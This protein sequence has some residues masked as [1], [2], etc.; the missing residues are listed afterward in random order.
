MTFSGDLRGISLADVFQNVA[1]NRS[2][3]W[4]EITAKSRTSHVRFFEGAVTGFSLGAGERLV[5]PEFLVQRG[6]VER[7]TMRRLLTKHRRSKKSPG[8]LAA[9]AKLLTEDDLAS[10]VLTRIEEQV[11]E[12]FMLREATFVFHDDEVPADLFD[13]DQDVGVVLEVGPLLMEGARRADEW[14]QIQRVLSSDRDFVVLLEGWDQVELGQFETDLATHM[15]GR[16]D[17]RTLMHRAAASRFDVMKALTTMI[18]EGVARLASAEEL[19]EF[20]DEAWDRGDREAAARLLQQAL[21]IERSNAEFRGRLVDWLVELGRTKDAGAE[22]AKMAHGAANQGDLEAAVELYG[23][24]AELDPGDVLLRE[25]RVELL[26]RGDDEEAHVAAVSELVEVYLEIGSADLARKALRT[27][28][29]F[30]KLRSHPELLER[31]A[32]VE[33]SL[34]HWEESAKIYRQLAD[35]VLTTDEDRC[36]SLLQSALEQTPDDDLLASRIRDIET[37]VAAKRSVGRRR[38]ATIAASVAVAGLVLSAGVMEF[39]ATRRVLDAFDGSFAMLRG[40]DAIESLATLDD[41]RQQL[42]WSPTRSRATE[43]FERLADLQLAAIEKLIERGDY[44]QALQTIDAL[45]A[46][47]DR[48]DLHTTCG[49]LRERISVERDAYGLLD[50]LAELEVD[51]HVDDADLDRIAGFDTGRFL[52]FH[53][54][55]LPRVRHAKI[56]AAMTNALLVIDSPRAVPVVARAYLTEQDSIASTG[57]WAVLESARRHSAADRGVAW[58]E[59][60]EQLEA[61]LLDDTTKGRARQVLDALFP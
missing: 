54:A 10:A 31:L 42:L 19:A 12:L 51:A 50:Q 18:H 45:V 17:V 27:A 9:L 60:R 40:G 15:D 8:R 6:F 46:A 16:T 41:V 25:R 58:Q 7:E 59:L 52:D 2:T 57:L 61:A 13:P 32:K 29:E 22:L 14:Q 43:L 47:V 49:S 21:Q 20:A 1:G 34:G 11:F 37:G 23:R 24:A 48:A 33:S 36:V 39:R 4:L 26:S 55:N 53:L 38:L 56:R 28:L 5:T 35:K 30:R 44:D 3:G